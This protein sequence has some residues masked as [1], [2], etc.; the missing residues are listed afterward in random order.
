MRVRMATLVKVLAAICLIVGVVGG[1]CKCHDPDN[2]QPSEMMFEQVEAAAVS[3]I[4]S[5]NNKEY[6]IRVTIRGGD[7]A[8]LIGAI[9]FTYDGEWLT[10]I[11]EFPDGEGCNPGNSHIV[12]LGPFDVL[13]N[14]VHI[15]Y[16][17]KKGGTVEEL[18][19]D[20]SAYKTLTIG[21]QPPLEYGRWYPLD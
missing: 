20:P 19:K 6:N 2:V 15:S 21:P 14:D 10:P 3:G 13:P 18:K 9:V 12:I 8:V 11:V 16:K 4:C 1:G 5:P 7:Y 17:T